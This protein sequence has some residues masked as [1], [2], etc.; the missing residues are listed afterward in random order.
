[1]LDED[2]FRSNVGIIICNRAGDLLW[3]KRI[4][5]NAWQFPQGGIRPGEIAEESLYREL[6]EEVGLTPDDVSILKRTR[7]WLRYR[8]PERLIRRG[9]GQL[10]IGQKQKWFL[11]SLDADESRIAFTHSPEPEFDDWRWVGYWA[12]MRQVVAFK[13]EVYRR[14][15]T[16]L[17][18]ARDRHVNGRG[19][20]KTSGTRRNATQ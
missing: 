3:A 15:L 5:Q 18:P 13:R 7:G 12:P 17:R 20:P 10:C 16:E 1:M 14:A 9:P 4:G 8:L 6:R 19:P 2:G 11:L